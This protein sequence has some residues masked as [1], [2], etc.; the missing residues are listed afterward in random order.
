MRTCVRMHVQSELFPNYQWWFEINK[1]VHQISFAL[2][3]DGGIQTMTYLKIEQTFTIC[4][5]HKIHSRLLWSVSRYIWLLERPIFFINTSIFFF[6]LQY[7]WPED[8]TWRYR[9]LESV[10][11]CHTLY[12]YHRSHHWGEEC[13]LELELDSM[14]KS[15]VMSCHMM[16][17]DMMW[18][19]MI[20]C[21][22]TCDNVET[23]KE[24][25]AVSNNTV[26]CLHQFSFLYCS[27]MI[28]KLYPCINRTEV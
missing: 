8:R 16:W 4:F 25:D 5:A 6:F 19:D 24:C 11:W 23:R 28:L 20:W 10:F 12:S 3:I 15:D 21:D 18:Y 9:R 27:H 1:I 26:K 13:S 2:L 7:I 14:M 22:V 17:C